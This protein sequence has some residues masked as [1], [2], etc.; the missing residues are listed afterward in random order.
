QICMLAIVLTTL[1]STGVT[2][3]AGLSK[4]KWSIVTSPNPGALANEL[5][6]ITALSASDIWAV[7][8][9]SNSFGSLT[10]TLIKHWDGTSWQVVASP[11]IAGDNN[12]LYGVAAVSATDIWAVGNYQPNGGG[13]TKTLIEHW[14]GTNWQIVSSPNPGS[15]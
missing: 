13:S 11:N 6:G 10:K 7:G 2:Q 1:L 3:A 4:G 5:W 15:I 14:N 8:D 12:D 9:Y